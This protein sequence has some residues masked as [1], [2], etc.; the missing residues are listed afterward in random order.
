[1]RFLFATA[2]MLNLVGI[3]SLI[4]SFVLIDT[5]NGAR[6]HIVENSQHDAPPTNKNNN[7][8]ADSS[9]QQPPIQ[10]Q[11]C[12]PTLQCPR[13]TDY[14]PACKES[15]LLKGAVL[16]SVHDPDNF[17][18]RLMA[19]VEGKHVA[20]VGDSLTRQWFETL[21][22]RLGLHQQVFYHESGIVPERIVEARRFNLTIDDAR[23]PKGMNDTMFGYMRAVPDQFLP[24]YP[25]D[26]LPTMMPR[27]STNSQTACQKLRT[28]LEY[29]KYD[30]LNRS[31][32]SIL[33]FVASKAD[34]V[35][36]NIG[37]H[38][39]YA[40]LFLH[41]LTFMMQQCEKINSME[42]TI[43][44]GNPKKKLCL[45]RETFA[46]HWVSK[47]YVE[48]D[49]TLD[50]RNDGIET[51]KDWKFNRTLM[52][53]TCG[54]F[55]PGIYPYRFNPNSY[56]RDISDASNVGVVPVEELSRNAWGWHKGG[57]CTHFCHDKELWDLV[58]QSL[59]DTATKS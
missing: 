4:R 27:Q 47:D 59:I 2:A 58:H 36:F 53:N 21:G 1:M 25:Q 54:P 39:T 18:H 9:Q 8:N 20:L 16:P 33:D 13:K 38:Y 37:V 19:F 5:I 45:Y 11:F 15:A 57:D 46:R 26:P 34:V 48:N 32:A 31:S 50:Y 14:H 49:P 7:N 23:S 42:A 24:F 44:G 51:P 28:T 40:K 43:N 41:D 30:T 35:I 56:V 22:C 29:Y 17:L 10:Q 6:D 52:R 12:L 3:L 55:L